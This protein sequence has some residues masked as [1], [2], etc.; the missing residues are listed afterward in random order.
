[1]VVS[2]C[3]LS[4]VVFLPFPCEYSPPSNCCGGAD[5]EEVLDVVY[6]VSVTRKPF[7]V[8]LKPLHE[9]QAEHKFLDAARQ[10]ISLGQDRHEKR[11]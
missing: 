10:K 7:S 11:R 3:F 8:L 1:M 6:H 2:G 9:A 4:L 5:E